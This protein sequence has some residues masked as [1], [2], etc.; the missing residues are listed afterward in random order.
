MLNNLLLEPNPSPVSKYDRG[1]KLGSLD[2]ISEK[3]GVPVP[4]LEQKSQELWED[5][6]RRTRE[7]ELMLVYRWAQG[8]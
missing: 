7:H 3:T 4:E 5:G 2:K 6:T 1:G 8:R